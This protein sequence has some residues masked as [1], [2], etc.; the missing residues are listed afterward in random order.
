MES[1]TPRVIYG[2][3]R[4]TGRLPVLPADS[5]VE[6]PCLVDATGFHPAAA[7]R[8]LDE[9]EARCDESAGAHGDLIPEGL[10]AAPRN[11]PSAGR[12]VA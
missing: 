1:G 5:C 9:V 10:K 3:I 11:I 6:V 4:G 2:N 8:M 7:T 12:R